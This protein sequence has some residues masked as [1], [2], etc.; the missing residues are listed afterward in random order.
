MRPKLSERQL[1]HILELLYLQA[2]FEQELGFIQCFYRFLLAE[3]VERLGAERLRQ[4]LDH[5]VVQVKETGALAVFSMLLRLQ[6]RLL[7][8]RQ[9]LFDIRIL[10]LFLNPV[11]LSSEC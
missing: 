3:E 5:L 8:W 9:L 10:S 11:L 1:K 6:E 7:S 4:V 2:H